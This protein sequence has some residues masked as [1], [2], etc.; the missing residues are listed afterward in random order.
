M[1]DFTSTRWTSRFECPAFS[2][3][4]ATASGGGTAAKPGYG[5]VFQL[6]P[7]GVFTPIHTFTAVSDGANP[8]GTLAHDSTGAIYGATN[9]GTVYKVKP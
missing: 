4:L 7:A 3:L 1:V 9:G 2:T 5:V 6:T 8:T